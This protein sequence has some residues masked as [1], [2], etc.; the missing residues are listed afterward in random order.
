VQYGVW[1]VGGR[2]AVKACRRRL[3]SPHRIYRLHDLEAEGYGCGGRLARAYARHGDQP[4]SPPPA[5]ESN[6]RGRGGGG[7][8]AQLQ[9]QLGATSLS[10]L[11]PGGI[12]KAPEQ[13][14]TD[15]SQARSAT[16]GR[17]SSL[18][19]QSAR[20]ARTRLPVSPSSLRDPASARRGC[21]TFSWA[22]A[23]I[24]LDSAAGAAR[25]RAPSAPANPVDT[26]TRTPPISDQ[27]ITRPKPP[28][29]KIPGSSHPDTPISPLP[30]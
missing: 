17:T 29:H 20:F 18:P 2:R 28:G 27:G 5:A 10:P 24:P 9:D 14:G 19:R 6:R 12:N 26:V 22:L 15:Q 3:I 8:C 21:G 11:A 30:P 1:L 25:P 7:G 4:T 16:G 13:H 23:D